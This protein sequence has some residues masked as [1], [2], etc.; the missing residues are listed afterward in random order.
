MFIA[1]DENKK[2][3]EA[4]DSV[5][6]NKY[7]CPCCGGEVIPN[8]GKIKAWYFSHISTKDCD[9]WYQPMTVWHKEWQEMFDPKFREIPMEYDGEKHRADI[10]IDHMVVE[11]QHSYISPEDFKKRN[12]FY[13]RD[14]VLVWLLDMKE[15]NID[16]FLKNR[17]VER[18][19]KIFLFME[20]EDN[21]IYEVNPYSS[22]NIGKEYT[23]EE[24]ID[25]LREIYRDT[26]TLKEKELNGIR[27]Y[28]KDL[29]HY[30]FKD[31][32]FNN[33]KFEKTQLFN[34]IFENCTF[35][36]CTFTETVLEE[37]NI[38]NCKINNCNF[39]NNKQMK[40][41]K[42]NDTEIKDSKFKYNNMDKSVIDTVKIIGS[43]IDKV[44]ARYIRLN[45]TNIENC[46]IKN[47]DLKQITYY[48]IVNSNNTFVKIPFKHEKYG[49]IDL[50]I[51]IEEIKRQR[52]EER[53]K[54]EFLEME[55]QNN[56]LIEK[57]KREDKETVLKMYNL[58]IDI[59]PWDDE[60]EVEMCN[61]FLG[62]V[63]EGTI[64]IFDI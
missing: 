62:A 35:N 22:C 12:D 39:T 14:G 3:I 46:S 51:P 15:K 6:G 45:N 48:N 63:E 26:K 36:N 18:K 55:R 41:V 56:L 50:E 60:E 30:K 42:I 16:R 47:T 53:K 2:R 13:S 11:F 44:Y 20:S 28:K 19:P 23:K 34:T 4:K 31:Y 59:C 32:N 17:P 61:L 58:D 49:I 54:R 64:T 9:T 8:Q 21:L 40:R 24:F 1:E 25:R 27:F 38:R 5:K 29:S 37:V 10:K 43:E 33:I 52:E 57:E 7:Y